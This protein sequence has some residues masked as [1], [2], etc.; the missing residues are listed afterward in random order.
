MQAREPGVHAAW[1]GKL[2]AWELVRQ[3]LLVAFRGDIA[4]IGH[5]RTRVVKFPLS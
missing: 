1:H 5:I 2:P 3:V 4:A